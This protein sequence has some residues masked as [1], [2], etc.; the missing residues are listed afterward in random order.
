[1]TS[2]GLL[3]PRSWPADCTIATVPA[4]FAALG[5]PRA[6]NDGDVY[7][8][9]TLVERDDATKATNRPLRPDGWG[10]VQMV[11]AAQNMRIK[12]PNVRE[13]R[14]DAHNHGAGVDAGPVSR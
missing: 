14:H 5:D 7:S 12:V 13:G 10:M 2:S 9:V 1:M 3:G 8:L 11:I 6:G 4:R